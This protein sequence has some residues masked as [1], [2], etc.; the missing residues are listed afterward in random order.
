MRQAL[1]ELAPGASL[2]L[3]LLALPFLYL[4]KLGLDPDPPR[5][6]LGFVDE[7]HVAGAWI[8]GS[9]LGVLALRA[10][11]VVRMRARRSV[12]VQVGAQLSLLS[13]GGMSNGKCPALG[14]HSNP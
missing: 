8:L 6:A 1:R 3:S 5:C 11:A 14:S 4:S 7:L 13:V 2:I 9:A 10:W 12:A